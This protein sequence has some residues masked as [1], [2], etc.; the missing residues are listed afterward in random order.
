MYQACKEHVITTCCMVQCFVW[1]KTKVR[2]IIDMIMGHKNMYSASKI[3]K[4]YTHVTTSTLNRHGTLTNI[5]I[6]NMWVFAL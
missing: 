1:V 6:L 2:E 4:F 5:L 3:L